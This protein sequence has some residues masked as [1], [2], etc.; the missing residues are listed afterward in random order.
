MKHLLTTKFYKFIC[1]D[2]QFCRNGC[3]CFNFK[4]ILVLNVIVCQTF[5]SLLSV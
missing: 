2:E 5:V 3:Y 1:L 4:P